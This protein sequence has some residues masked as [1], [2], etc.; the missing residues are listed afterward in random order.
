MSE[1]LSKKSYQVVV[2]DESHF[3]KDGKSQRSQAVVPLLKAAKRAICLTG[4]P[5]LS[6]PIELYSQLEALRPNVFTKHKDFAERYCAGNRFG[7]GGCQN[8]DELNAVISRLV[9]V[10]RLKK[11]V[12]TQLPPKQRE[13]VF[14]QLPKSD[15]LKQV[16]DVQEKLKA[17]KEK[18]KNE[19]GDGERTMEEK[20]LMNSLYLFSARAK[21]VPVAHYLG[22]LLDAGGS[23]KFLFFA[24]HTELLDAAEAAVK[25][26]GVPSIRIDGSTP[27]SVRGGL[28]NRF[29]EDE[30]VRVAVLSIK[31]A[32]MGITLT[33]ASTVIFGEL[34][35]T[36]GDIVQAEDRAH[37]IGQVSSV[38]VQFLC[39][40]NTVDDIMWASVQ[41]KLENLGQV[42]DGTSGDH[43][44][45][46]EGKGGGSSKWRGG[47][48]SR[49]GGGAGGGGGGGGEGGGDGTNGG[50]VNGGGVNGGGGGGGGGVCTP[51][52][53]LLQ[54]TSR[55]PAGPTGA[56]GSQSTPKAQGTL[57]GFFKTSGGKRERGE[58][59]GGGRGGGGEGNHHGGGDGDSAPNAAQRQAYDR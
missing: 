54:H 42:L 7:W 33:A 41:N 3:L 25:Q 2:C 32:G 24:H 18:Q 26:R 51:A 5:A 39:A 56:P 35:W 17:I 15:A 19:G 52:R 6:R 28:V 13:Q 47:G 16:R 8:A 40:K 53:S 44:E 11:D 55:S 22:E 34:T 9:M 37:R 4:T 38:N 21:L 10:R 57:D 48:V 46:H 45:L 20:R 12:L 36:P 58:D 14:L 59:R 1:R 31:A 43:L 30:R 50:G 49:G 29:Q 27:T 23:E